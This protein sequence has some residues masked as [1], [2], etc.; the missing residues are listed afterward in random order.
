MNWTQER[1]EELKSLWA[2]GHSAHQIAKI[3]GDVSRN[4][5]IG[6]VHRLGLAG[7][8][9]ASRP[10]KRPPRLNA[11]PHGENKVLAA[12]VIL[13]FVAASLSLDWKADEPKIRGRLAK[14]PGGLLLGMAEFFYSKGTFE[15]IFQPTISDMREE[16]FEALSADRRWKAR[17]VVLRGYLAYLSAAALHAPLSLVRVLGAIWRLGS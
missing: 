10:V 2:E 12:V 6:K 9:T 13:G 16:Y 8:A 11:A 14:P 5:V 15:R 4:A 17:L 1:V 3:F 7:R